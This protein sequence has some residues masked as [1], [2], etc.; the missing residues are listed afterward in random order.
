MPFHVTAIDRW[1]HTV[2]F[3]AASTKGNKQTNI[4]EKRNFILKRMVEIKKSRSK[5]MAEHN[6]HYI[7]SPPL[8]L[9]VLS[10]LLY[11]KIPNFI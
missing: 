4:I 5:V 10:S 9:C 2:F 3:N 8:Q 6:I 11:C 7:A 1:R